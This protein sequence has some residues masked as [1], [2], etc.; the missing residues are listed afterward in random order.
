M[1]KEFLLIIDGFNEKYARKFLKGFGRRL[2]EVKGITRKLEKYNKGRSYILEEKN[3]DS[4]R[5][6]KAWSWSFDRNTEKHLGGVIIPNIYESFSRLLNKKGKLIEIGEPRDALTGTIYR[7]CCRNYLRG[8]ILHYLKT[9][10]V[11]NLSHTEI[12]KN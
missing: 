9:L 6:S 7:R 2:S 4:G 11:H 3:L 5:L 10:S 1:G 8:E 12:F